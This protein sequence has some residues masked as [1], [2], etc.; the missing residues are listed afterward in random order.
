[1][2]TRKPLRNRELP[3][4]TTGFPFPFLNLNEFLEYFNL[5]E[6]KPPLKLP[7]SEQKKILKFLP[8][9]R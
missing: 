6:A 8:N 4:L 9:I 7:W 5:P 2:S 3:E 1:M